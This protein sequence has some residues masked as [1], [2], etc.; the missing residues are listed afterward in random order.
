MSAEVKSKS[1]RPLEVL[2]GFCRILLGL[3]FMFSGIV[4]AIDPVGTQI[5]F[6][7]YLY[8]FG[9][10]GM[11][12]D[13]TLLILACILAGFEILMG[14]Y[15]FVGAF[16][17]GTSLLTLIMMGVFT[18]FTLY[19]ALKNP[20]EDC[21]CFGDALVLTNWQTF[22]KNVLLLILAVVVFALRKRIRPF[23][24]GRRQ[25]IVTVLITVIA[26]KFM[27][28]NIENLPVLDFRPYKVGT[29]LRAE[30]LDSIKNPA[31]SDFCIMDADMNDITPDVLNDPGY[32]FLVVSP[33]VEE[34]SEN[35]LDLIDDV[36]DYCSNWGYNMIGLTSSGDEAVRQWI[37]N[38]GA[39]IGFMFCDE[40][41]LQTMVRSNP[42]LVLIKDGVIVNK[43]SYSSIPSDQVLSGPLDEISV[44]RVP[45]PDPVRTPWAVAI[46]F[47]V[48]LLLLMVIDK[49][50]R[51]IQ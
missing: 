22:G 24:V 13:S 10:G 40:V 3:T 50:K 16:C 25:W 49:L 8:A 5:K 9:M 19:L 20:V 28:G 36:F 12:L 29:N 26:V 45:D 41:P 23:V 43:W 35:G 47:V 42:G 18:P 33:H 34:A 38:A 21:G 32:T 4:K 15:L 14:A 51:M 11:M 39:E 31:L 1:N 48:P 44:G 6:S 27:V 30:V 37:E 2:A 17:R 7:D 46:L